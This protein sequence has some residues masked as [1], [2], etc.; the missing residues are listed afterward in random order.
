MHAFAGEHAGAAD[1]DY[2]KP[3]IVACSHGD[4]RHVEGSGDEGEDGDDEGH[5]ALGLE[6]P[7][8]SALTLQ[9]GFWD[10]S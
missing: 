1:D 5:H 10:S 4:D 9:Q 2:D 6:Q 8:W 7:G 3:V